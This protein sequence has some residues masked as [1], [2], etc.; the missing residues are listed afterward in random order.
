MRPRG[1]SGDSGN[2]DEPWR[3]TAPKPSASRAAQLP[4][5]QSFQLANGLTVLF[6]PQT[7]LP[8]VSA[9]LVVRN[10]GDANPIDKPGL[11]SFSA[12]MLNQGTTTRTATQIAEDI[13]QLGA[14]LNIGST[15]DSSTITTSSL[16][17]NF[18]AALNILADVALRSTFPTEEVERIR[19][20]R[21]ADVVQ[22]RSNP[23]IVANNVMACGVVRARASIWICPARHG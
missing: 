5:P 10:G 17:R 8:V 9:T 16:A 11:A 14:S 7:G 23:N 4:T 2:P 19:A 3:A 6:S 15:M 20:A 1:E 22:Q 18:P 12:A 13:A 21:L